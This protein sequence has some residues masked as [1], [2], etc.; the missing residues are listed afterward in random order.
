MV[1]NGLKHRRKCAFRVPKLFEI[2]KVISVF[3]FVGI[4]NFFIKQL[5]ITLAQSMKMA[6]VLGIVKK[7]WL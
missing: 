1:E 6:K 5:I 2:F 4:K 3:D 7:I